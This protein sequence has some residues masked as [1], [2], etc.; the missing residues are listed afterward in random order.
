MDADLNREAEERSP[1]HPKP[2]RYLRKLQIAARYG[3]HER[4]VP[5]MVEDGR[6]RPP[7]LYNGRFPLWDADKLDKD[8]RAAARALHAQRKRNVEASDAA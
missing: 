3:V 6:L 7:D 5:R 2:K 4:T 8:D 1:E